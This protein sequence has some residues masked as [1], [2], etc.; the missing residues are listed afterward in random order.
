[1]L[2]QTHKKNNDTCLMCNAQCCGTWFSDQKTVQHMNLCAECSVFSMH[3]IHPW[4]AMLAIYM[5]FIVHCQLLTVFYLLAAAHHHLPQISIKTVIIST[6]ANVECWLQTHYYYMTWTSFEKKNNS[7]T[8]SYMG[9]Q[10][11]INE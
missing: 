9:K 7:Q 6:I 2:M 11:L 4:C 1:M 3:I 10:V 5:I 8:E